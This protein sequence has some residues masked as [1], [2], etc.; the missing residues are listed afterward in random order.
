MNKLS[1]EI[2][3]LSFNPLAI[4]RVLIFTI[5]LLLAAHITAFILTV[6]LQSTSGLSRNMERYFDFNL[7]RNFPTYFSVMLLAFTAVLLLI[8]YRCSKINHDKTK[9][10]WLVLALIFIFMSI[11][12]SIQVHEH[13]AEIL[14]PKL[15][16]DLSGL[17][18]WSW[19]IVYGFLFLVVCI[20]MLRFVLNLPAF[21]RKMFFLSAFLF[22]GGAL[23]LELLEGYFFKLY[24][25]NHI[26][27]RVLYCI[28]ELL[29]M[30]GV[31]IFI[32][33]LLDY[34]AAY[35]INIAFVSTKTDGPAVE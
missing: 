20:Y 24:G 1:K 34:L 21:T 12:E 15:S 14:R 5:L 18:Y 28:E 30:F 29:E 16:S 19:V 35:K 26:Y 33:G 2:V 6:V 3:Q 13:L 11:D 22:V 7:E 31:S 10:Y 23:G 17:L 8:I 32:Y 9:R 27:N 4:L 25:I